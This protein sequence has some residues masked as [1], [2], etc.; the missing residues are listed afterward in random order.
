MQQPVTILRNPRLVTLVLLL[1]TMAVASL[2]VHRAI[3]EH[4]PGQS[5]ELCIGLDRL[6]AG[7]VPT[8]VPSTFFVAF[9]FIYVVAFALPLRDRQLT[10]LRS[11]GPPAL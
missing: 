3:D 10:S 8:A 9:C 2:V 7:I 6:G 4:A 11:R 1:V 5:C